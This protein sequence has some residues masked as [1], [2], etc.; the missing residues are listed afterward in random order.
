MSI[1]THWISV[2]LAALQLAPVIKFSPLAQRR[3]GE[4]ATEV[5]EWRAFAFILYEH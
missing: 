1:N 3:G 5:G 4:P 2:T